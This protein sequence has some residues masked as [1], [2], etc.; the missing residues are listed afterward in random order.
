MAGCREQDD[1]SAGGVVAAACLVTLGCGVVGGDVSRRSS[2]ALTDVFPDTAIIR[3]EED[4]ADPL[5]SIG[6]VLELRDGSLAVSDGMIPRIRRFDASGRLLET[7]G[8]HGDAP[9]EFRSVGGLTEDR[10][11]RLVAIDPRLGRATIF[12]DGLTFDTTV[13]VTPSPRGPALAWGDSILLI[14]SARARSAAITLMIGWQPQWSVPSPAPASMMEYPY[15]NSFGRTLTAASPTLLF[16]AFSLR[17]PIYLYD[18]RGGL[19]DS[20]GSA[21]D[22]FRRA[23]MV[24][25]GAFAGSGARQRI[26]T[27]LAKFDVIANLVVVNDTLLVVGHGV[28]RQTA[29]SLSTDEHHVDVYHI[30]TRRKLFEDLALP[31]GA[32]VLA[33]GT[34]LHVLL[35]Q[36]PAP[37][38][39]MRVRMQAGPD[40]KTQ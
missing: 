23:P 38:T 32:A 5:G 33:G 24:E 19:V 20:L 31:E 28:L 15:W 26:E 12:V 16:T 1:A 30:P 17:Y 6:A 25:R 36:P 7:F 10:A 4:P 22:S 2:T 8:R 18:R 29:T 11:G 21:P 40:R 34:A 13:S 39:V 14:T 9:G 35:K 3:I 37:W 27:W